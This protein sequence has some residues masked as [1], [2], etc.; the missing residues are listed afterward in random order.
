MH[1]HVKTYLQS[2]DLPEGDNWQ[3]LIAIMLWALFILYCYFVLKVLKNYDQFSNY[4]F[5]VGL[6]LIVFPI[7][8]IITYYNQTSKLEQNIRSF[9]TATY[10]LY[11]VAYLENDI[12]SQQP[13]PDIYYII[14]DA[15]SRSDILSDI[16]GDD[17]SLFEECLGERG[18][19]IATES[20]SNYASTMASLSSSLNMVYLE[21]VTDYV[22]QEG[23]KSKWVISSALLEMLSNNRLM[24]IFKAQGYSLVSFDSGFEMVSFSD[25][26]QYMVAPEIEESNYKTK[27]MFELFILNTFIEDIYLRLNPRQP[28]RMSSIFDAHCKR[29]IFTFESIPKF[30]SMEGNYFVFAHIVAPHPPF[31][32]GPNGEVIDGQGAFTLADTKINRDVQLY[33]DE[34][35]YVN[36]LVLNMVDQII[37]TSETPPIIIV[38]AEQ[39]SRIYLAEGQSTELKE[40]LFFPIFNA[41][42]LPD[43][44]MESLL[45]PSISPVNSFRLILN[46]YFGT[47]LTL[48]PDESFFWDEDTNYEFIHVPSD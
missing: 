47:D 21:S 2:V 33:L 5:T 10:D 11:G 42:Y 41:Y 7:F 18:F 19:Y 4:L 23:V 36:S 34:L 15:Y 24:D 32:F 48:L 46:N 13:L 6:I 1:G 27:N 16:Y 14:L 26:D 29:L 39:G 30:A 3:T 45:Y 38:Q 35:H 37:E 9:R 8:S 17:N 43:V 22:A 44:D 40:E 25:I 12:V 31:V 28:A 20:K